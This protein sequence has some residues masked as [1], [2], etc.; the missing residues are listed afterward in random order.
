MQTIRDIMNEI[1][2][3]IESTATVREAAQLMANEDIGF[4]PVI[5]ENVSIG[6]L[7][8]RD[9]VVRGIACDLDLNQTPVT[10]ILSAEPPDREGTEEVTNSRIATLSADTTVDD[11]IR[12]MDQ[13]HF[14]RVPVHDK[15]FNIIG[16]VSR[17]ELNETATVHH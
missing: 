4:L 1:V 12:F 9:I 5:H 16:V 2:W 11:A 13:K 14:R 6:V 15:D 7:T 10:S 3:T 8:D 17:S